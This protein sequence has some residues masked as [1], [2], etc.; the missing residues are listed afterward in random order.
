MSRAHEHPSTAGR[1]V[2]VDARKRL[3]V[4]EMQPGGL[5]LV[6]THDDGTIILEPAVAMSVREAKARTLGRR[7]IAS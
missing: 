7:P 1:L 4:A 3:T 5:Y 2:Q 6:T